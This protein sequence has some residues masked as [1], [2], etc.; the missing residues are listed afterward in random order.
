VTAIH[1]LFL[2]LRGTAS[3]NGV[4]VLRT[5]RILRVVRLLRVAKVFS[6]CRAVIRTLQTILL[7]LSGSASS[8]VS[9]LVMLFFFLFMFAVFFMQGVK[10]FIASADTRE[11]ETAVFVEVTSQLKEHYGS[12]ESCLW[13]LV[14]AVSGGYD[15][16]EVARPISALG[17]FYKLAFLMYVLFVLFALLNILT[18]IFVNVA[19]DSCK[20]NREIAIDAAITNK[21][22]IIKEIVDL[23]H[24]ADTDC[25]GTLS[26]EEFEEY[27]QDERIK[28]FFMALEL[29]MSA[30]QRVFNLID[31]S[32]D[33]QLDI[34]EFVQGCID[35]R[36]SSKKV[37]IAI[38]E[39]DRLALSDRLDR[40]DSMLSS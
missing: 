24:E 27:I 3:V 25:S 9:A 17:G 38:L 13:T 18:G 21:N 11:R 12:M 23:F 5:F 19:I 31:S 33:G 2:A 1:E 28:A 20:M 37:D 10:G 34:E 6:P 40:L 16:A 35:L 29:D 30:A 4:S 14:G 7:S 22:S 32:G 39:K 36:G 8:F 15:W 26:W